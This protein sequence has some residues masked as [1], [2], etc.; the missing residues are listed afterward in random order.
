MQLV[1][2]REYWPGG[3]N[4]I[5]TLQSETVSVTIEPKATHFGSG[6]SCIPEGVYA[7]R[8]EMGGGEKIFLTNAGPNGRRAGQS[9]PELGVE[10]LH[11]NIVL[12]SEITGEGR[13]VPNRDAFKQL[14]SLIGQALGKGERATLE[15]RSYPEAALNLTYHQIRWMD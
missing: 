15:I 3:T 2:N 9:D 11:R 5:L 12:V 7:L 6:L 8:L 13:G 4:G 1:L 10:Q 14:V